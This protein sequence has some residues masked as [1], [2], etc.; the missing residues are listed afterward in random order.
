MNSLDPCR[1]FRVEPSSE[2]K[3]GLRQTTLFKP[4]GL[5]YWYAVV[6]LHHIVFSGMILGIQREALQIA[7]SEAD[8]NT[9][10]DK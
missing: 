1:R 8:I 7:A 2:R 5:L 4:F 10:E 9:H 3:C 6:P